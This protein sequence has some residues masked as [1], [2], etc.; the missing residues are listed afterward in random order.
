MAFSLKPNEEIQV[1]AMSAAV[2]YSIFQLNVPLKADVLAAQPHNSTV[3]GSVK[4]AAYTATAITAGIA[5]V[6]KSPTVFIV[7]AAVIIVESWSYYRANAIQ[8]ATGKVS[9]P[10]QFGATTQPG[11]SGN[12]PA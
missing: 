3:H 4:T 10:S 5:L 1:S 6:S 2:V 9:V 12:G 8:P 7:G 11:S